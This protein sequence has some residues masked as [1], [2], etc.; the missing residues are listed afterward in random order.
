MKILVAYDG[1]AASNRAL[2]LAIDKAKANGARVYVVTSMSKGTQSQL[3]DI[4]ET[5]KK[6]DEIK[7]MLQDQNISADT[8]LLIR[9]VEPGEDVVEFAKEN[10]ID[11][12]F[13]ANRKRSRVEKMILGSTAQYVILNAHCPVITVK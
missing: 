11:E 1:S 9:G 6:L 8:A 4:Q 12:I 13:V 7:K 5:E 10:E 3:H 2:N